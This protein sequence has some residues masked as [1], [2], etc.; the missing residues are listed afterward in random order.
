MAMVFACLRVPC[1]SGRVGV[2]MPVVTGI[3]TGKKM[4]TSMAQQRNGR[5]GHRQN[6]TG[7]TLEHRVLAG[8]RDP[9]YSAR[10]SRLSSALL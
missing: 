2:M 5:K 7:E 3:A 6:Q 4:Q 9:H 1:P 10:R 8:V